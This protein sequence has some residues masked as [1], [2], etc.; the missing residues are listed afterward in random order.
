MYRN[1]IVYVVSI[2]LNSSLYGLG[3]Y[4]LYGF[5]LNKL[6]IKKHCWRWLG[7]EM[8]LVWITWT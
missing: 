1:P 7:V 4:G 2:L 8:H 3:D 5:Y 6:I